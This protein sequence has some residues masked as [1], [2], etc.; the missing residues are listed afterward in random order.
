MGIW[1]DEIRFVFISAIQHQMTAGKSAD[2]G[3]KKEAWSKVVIEVQP[4]TGQASI[5]KI[6]ASFA[7]TDIK[8]KIQHFQIIDR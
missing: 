5:Y 4:K 8:K 3:L 6:T 7:V 1:T 2:T